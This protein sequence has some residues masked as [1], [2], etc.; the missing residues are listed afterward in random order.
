MLKFNN[1]E[2]EQC[3]IHSVIGSAKR[4]NQFK[5]DI[6]G[7]FIGYNEFEREEIKIDYRAETLYKCEKITHVHKH[8]L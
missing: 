2:T 5:C 3:T 7:K 4:G 6:C 1:E 8:C